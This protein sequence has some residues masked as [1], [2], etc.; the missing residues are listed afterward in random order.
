[1]MKAL[2]GGA[3]DEVDIKSPL[4]RVLNLSSNDAMSR[5]PFSGQIIM[6]DGQASQ[7]ARGAAAYRAIHQKLEKG[8]IFKDPLASRII[9]QETAAA[10]DEI[11]ANDSLRPWRLFIAARSRFSEDTMGDCIA[12]GVRQVVVLGAG[13]DTFSL[14][15]PYAH[16]GV[17]TF[18]VDYPSTQMWKRD[19]IRTAGLAEPPSLAFAPVDFERESL[20]EGLVKAG[21]KLNEQAFFQW[22]GVVPYLTK[23][24]VSST[25]KFISE[26]P[27]AA[28]AFDYVEPFQNY[29]AERRAS[30]MATAARAAS[31]GEP[32]LSFFDPIELLQLLQGE[33]FNVI[34]DLGLFEIAERYYG[35]LRRDIVFGPGPHIVRAHR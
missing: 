23:D 18:E 7:T 3:L 19:Q 26:V 16:L 17:R 33:R 27:Q 13:L 34:E 15:N 25:L 5:A 11:A 6:R 32:W 21:F 31:R 14:R 1:M 9:D 8:A 35:V 28:V 10:L 2:P 12:C 24:A 30:V 4:S 22:L 29:P 20:A